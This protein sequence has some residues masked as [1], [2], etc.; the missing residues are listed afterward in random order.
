MNTAQ[1]KP[2]DSGE[3]SHSNVGSYRNEWNRTE[4]PEINLQIY[5]QLIPTRM[6]RQLNGGKNSL[7]QM[8]LGQLEYPHAEEGN[9]TPISDHT[10]K[11]TQG[12]VKFKTSNY[13]ILRRRYRYRS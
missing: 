3:T 10:Q 7:K 9:Q 5:S 6:P 8:V 11:L 13:K 4:G 12:G 1:R 2:S